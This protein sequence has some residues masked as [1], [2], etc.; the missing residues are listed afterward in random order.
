MRRLDPLRPRRSGSGAGRQIGGQAVPQLLRRPR[1]DSPATLLGMPSGSDDRVYSDEEARAVFERAL[2]LDMKKSSQ[3]LRHEELLAAAREVGLSD[4]TVEKAIEEMTLARAADEA[5]A[6]IIQR[7]RRGFT[8]H[9]I[10]FLAVNTF[11]FLLNWIFSPWIWWAV[12]PLLFW[13]LGLFFHAWAA[14]SRHVK[15]KALQREMLRGSDPA[16][17]LA[18]EGDREARRRQRSQSISRNTQILGDTVEEGIAAVLQK[19]TDELQRR[20]GPPARTRVA[21]E[22]QRPRVN[23]EEFEDHHDWV[24]KKRQRRW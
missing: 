3:G 18:L 2:E 21:D 14:F 5:R 22:R 15:P 4:A 20:A 8:N 7:R 16:V 17:R 1:A 11:L 13:G 10:P 24:D 23:E 6:V 9:L 19:V 12:I